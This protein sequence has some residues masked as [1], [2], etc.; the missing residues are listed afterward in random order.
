MGHR[1]PV[2]KV[3]SNNDSSRA[4]YLNHNQ[5]AVWAQW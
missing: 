4:G 2:T 1:K 5:H 3:I